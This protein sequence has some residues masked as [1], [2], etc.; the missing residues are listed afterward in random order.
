MDELFRAT[1]LLEE[2]QAASQ[3]VIEET[4]T[5]LSRLAAE[6]ADWM[7]RVAI[8]EDRLVEER[9]TREEMARRLWAII[10]PLVGAVVG[11]LVTYFLKR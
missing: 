9:R 3:N 4:R 5:D 6:F 8:L 7:T 2:R 11:G 10:G 1:T